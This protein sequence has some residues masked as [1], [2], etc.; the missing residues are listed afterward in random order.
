MSGCQS[1]GLDTG[2]KLEQLATLIPPD[3]TGGRRVLDGAFSVLDALA[4]ADEGLGL[5]ALARASG[6]AKTSAHRLAEQLV[7]LGAVESSNHRYFVGPRMMR[8]GQR[9][10]PDPVLRRCAQRP[11]H[12]LPCNRALW[13]RCEFCMT[14]D[15]AISV[16]LCLTV[17]LVCPTTSTPNRSHAPPPDV[18]ST[19]RSRP[20]R[21]RS[22]IAGPNANGANSV[23]PLP[24]RERQWLTIRTRFPAFVVYQRPC[25]GRMGPAPAQSRSPSTRPNCPWVCQSYCPALPFVLV[26]LFA[27]Y[28]RNDTRCPTGHPRA[29]I[30]DVTWAGDSDGRSWTGGSFE[31]EV[32]PPLFKRSTRPR[33]RLLA[34]SR[35]VGVSARRATL[36]PGRGSTARAPLL[37]RCPRA[38]MATRPGA[39]GRGADASAH[40]GLWCRD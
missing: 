8:I 39:A 9:W 26:L 22:L 30:A 13:R 10:Q 35:K 14:I 36:G 15:S 29:A 23:I 12:T 2:G 31:G 11:V 34:G 16:L 4:H 20:A 38:A 24:I 32:Q 40:L 28:R 17:T 33:W 5:T 18:C 6:L 37:H 3:T 7:T 19:P 27:V 25:G 21:S 1:L